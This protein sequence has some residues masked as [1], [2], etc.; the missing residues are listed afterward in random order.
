M[1]RTAAPQPAPPVFRKVAETGQPPLT[2][3]CPLASVDTT[4]KL[5]G[6]L[7]WGKMPFIAP[8]MA[9]TAVSNA[10]APEMPA[11]MFQRDLGWPGAGSRMGWNGACAEPVPTGTHRW[12]SHQYL[13]S[14]EYCTATA[15][16][17]R[18]LWSRVTVCQ[19]VHGV[20]KPY[21]IQKGCLRAIMAPASTVVVRQELE[22]C[23]SWHQPLSADVMAALPE[24][25]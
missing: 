11:T 24:P 7:E 6:E 20:V 1:E 19:V 4:S 5:G 23:S 22:A 8:M 14:G 21:A 18:Q 9:A 16:V 25:H 15:R 12:P 2:V 17:P 3:H 10:A 13:P